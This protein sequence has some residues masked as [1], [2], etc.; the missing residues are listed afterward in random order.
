MGSA[1]V[2]VV[3]LEVELVEVDDEVVLEVELVVAAAVVATVSSSVAAVGPLLPLHAPID[4]AAAVR[5]TVR[6]IIGFIV[7]AALLLCPRS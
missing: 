1:S 7:P 2:V 3:V 4:S 5:N 6:R